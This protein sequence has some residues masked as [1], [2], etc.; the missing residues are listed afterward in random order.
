MKTKRQ[1][2][3]ILVAG[4]MAAFG[5]ACGPKSAP[6]SAA[7]PQ[8]PL[9][10]TINSWIGW[11]PL[12]LA[13]K[14]GLNNGVKMEITRVEDTGARKSTMIAQRVDGYASSVDN[15]SLDSA[16]GVPGKIVMCFDESFGG[17]GIVCKKSIAKVADLKGKKIG[18]QKGLPS[19]FLLLTVLQK[20]GLTPSDI[21]QEDLDADK[22]GAAF[23]AGKLDAAVTWEPWISKAAET[24]DGKILVTTKD[25]PGLIV[26][27]LVFRD[28]IL[29]KRKDDVSKVIAGWFAALDYWKSHKEEADKI[30]ADA[31]G[32][33]LEE[34]KDMCAGVRFFDKA[35]NQAYF[36][37][38]NSGEIYR[39]F[40][41]AGELWRAAGVIQKVENAEAKIDPSFIRQ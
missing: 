14:K 12:Y 22:A 5:A 27:T 19:H 15:F 21:Q 23:A 7:P 6:P 1:F 13:D 26:D 40:Q 8:P 17:D 29:G 30:M 2:L 9:K 4:L 3:G 28:E 34:F 32:L 37:K 20:A 18:F 36:G 16:Q 38:D 31:Y 39:I 41:S 10:L 24:A 25:F 11:A 33:K 35:R